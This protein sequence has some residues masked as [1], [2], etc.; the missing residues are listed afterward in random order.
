MLNI[1]LKPDRSLRAAFSFASGALMLAIGLSGASAQELQKAPTATA[2]FDESS[3]VDLENTFWTCDWSSTLIRL[4][5]TQ[6]A[7]CAA[8]TEELKARKFGGEFEKLLAW[9]QRNKAA[10]HE[11]LNARYVAELPR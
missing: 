7:S 4:S 3:L 5:A 11:S 6:I 1:Q 2:I 8:A 10:A 9:W